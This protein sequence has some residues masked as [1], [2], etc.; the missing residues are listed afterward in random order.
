MAADTFRLLLIENDVFPESVEVADKYFELRN[1]TTLSDGRTVEIV[2]G[3]AMPVDVNDWP[4]NWSMQML[5]GSI[6]SYII[7]N[8][9]EFDVIDCDAVLLSSHF[10]IRVYDEKYIEDNLQAR[11]AL[12]GGASLEFFLSKYLYDGKPV[13]RLDGSV[14]AGFLLDWMD[15]LEE[16]KTKPFG[17]V[18]IDSDPGMQYRWYD[19]YFLDA[20]EWLKERGY[21]VITDDT[22]GQPELDPAQ[23]YGLYMGW[24]DDYSQSTLVDPGRDYFATGDWGGAFGWHVRSSTFWN[25]GKIEHQQREVATN[26]V[27][28]AIKNGYA[29]TMG[30]VYEPGLMSFALQT[31]FLQRVLVNKEPVG[32]A[33]WNAV[34]ASAADAYHHRMSYV[35]DPL[36]SPYWMD[37]EEPNVPPIDDPVVSRELMH[38]YD[39]ANGDILEMWIAKK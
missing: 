5:D 29:F 17:Q 3:R 27:V 20:A 31:D 15:R 34:P 37:Q 6:Q 18:V 2:R 16:A 8:K 14:N 39:L 11:L 1:G 32:L 19:Q 33:A 35:G 10:P 22:L 12:G 13:F 21:D 38:S 25:R 30:S 36:W 24:Y 26:W 7:V 28:G 23:K 9:M 4:D